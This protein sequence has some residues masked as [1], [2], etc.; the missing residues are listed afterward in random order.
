MLTSG[1][2]EP[3]VANCLSHLRIAIILVG[4]QELLHPCEVEI[5]LCKSSSQLDGIR[6]RERHV[7][8]EHQRKAFA[9]EFSRLLAPLYV[10][11]HALRSVALAVRAGDLAAYKTKLLS[12]VWPRSG[13]IH[14]E[15]GLRGP[16]QEHVDRLLPNLAQQVPEGQVYSRHGL[17]WQTFATIV[18]GRPEHLVPHQFDVSWILPLDEAAKMMLHNVAR[19]SSTNCHPHS[20]GAIFRFN[21]NYHATQRIDAPGFPV[22]LIRRMDGHR[23]CNGDR[24]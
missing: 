3:E 6:H 19:R 12:D 22:L 7:T 21:L 14:R 18:E 10:L 8:I 15:E 17:N 1:Q 5:W 9:D 2:H 16:T 11:A 13:R 23:V 24:L 4:W 20:T